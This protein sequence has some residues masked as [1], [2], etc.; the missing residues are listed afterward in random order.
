MGVGLVFFIGGCGG[1]VVML[2]FMI[3]RVNLKSVKDCWWWFVNGCWIMGGVISLGLGVD[4][5]VRY[6]FEDEKV[7]EK[8]EQQV[9]V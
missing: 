5:L 1:V 6:Y 8:E 9:N 4:Y 3:K 7:V 2:G